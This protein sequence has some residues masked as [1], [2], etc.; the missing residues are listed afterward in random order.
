MW[1]A[2]YHILVSIKPSAFDQNHWVTRHYITGLL[3]ANPLGRATN[4]FNCRIHFVCRRLGEPGA[5]GCQHC[6]H[7]AAGTSSLE[8]SL[9]AMYWL[10]SK[11]PD[12]T[13]SRK[14]RV[15]SKSGS[16]GDNS[17]SQP[18][19]SRLVRRKKGQKFCHSPIVETFIFLF[20]LLC[21]PNDRRIPSAS[22]RA[23]RRSLDSTL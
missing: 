2:V 6:A 10:M 8:A 19:A 11:A 13:S 3:A 7:W 4:L 5:G 16:S 23:A 20:E 22:S 9:S 1:V 21:F 15:S 17:S 18:Q 12:C 14:A